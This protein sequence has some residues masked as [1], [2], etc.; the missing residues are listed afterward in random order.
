M[1]WGECSSTPLQ[2]R[3]VS[4]RYYLVAVLNVHLL[5]AQTG[6]PASSALATAGSGWLGDPTLLRLA[7]SVAL[8][9]AAV[10]CVLGRKEF[11]LR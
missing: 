7:A 3:V 4:A 1:R 6:D 11:S 2:S 10:C 8:V 9:P 5:S